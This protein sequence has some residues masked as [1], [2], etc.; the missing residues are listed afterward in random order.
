MIVVHI[1]TTPDG[2]DLAECYASLKDTDTILVNPTRQEVIDALKKHPGETLMGLGHGTSGGLLGVEYGMAID[3]YMAPL[4]KD[5]EIIGIWCY[6]KEFGLNFGLKGFFTSMFVSNP[7]EASYFSFKEVPESVTHERNR[8]FT[9]K[10]RDLIA[11]G[12]PLDQWVENLQDYDRTLD[13]E[14]FNYENLA[15]LDGTQ[16]TEL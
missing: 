9:R 5:R 3:G 4:L 12:T 14:V 11:N 15:Y 6:A 16:E 8:A 10:I 7:D 1:D 2:H 13:F